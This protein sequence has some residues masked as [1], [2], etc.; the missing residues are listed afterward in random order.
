MAF[1]SAA[2]LAGAAS[3]DVATVKPSLAARSGGEG[4]RWQQVTYTPTSLTIRNATLSECIQ[5]AYDIR[6][7][8]VSGPHWISDD[9]YDILAKTEIPSSPDTLKLMLQALL[10][11]RFQLTVR[12]DPRTVPVFRLAAGRGR[13]KLRE[14]PPSAQESLTISN[15]SFLFQHV[16]MDRLAERAADFAGIDRPVV[17]E[18]GITGFFDLTLDG[19]AQAIRDGDTAPLF[20]A[21]ERLGLKLEAARRPVELLVVDRAEKP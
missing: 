2:L 3:F 12:R 19:V 9:R 20:A 18:T 14:S 21:L 15:G 10:A 11:D 1:V 7:Y 16:S 8:Q 13:L 5:W 17:N 4:S 6:F